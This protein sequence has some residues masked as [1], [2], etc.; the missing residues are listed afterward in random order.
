MTV[1]LVSVEPGGSALMMASRSER[2]AQYFPCL[3]LSA[4]SQQYAWHRPAF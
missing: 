2:S 4:L 3:Q 1:L